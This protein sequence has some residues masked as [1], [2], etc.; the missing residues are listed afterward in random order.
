MIRT[1]ILTIGDESAGSEAAVAMRELLGR[2]PF[3]E[4]DYS[5]VPDE[6]A[7]IRAQLRIWADGG[8]VDLVLTSG[9]IGLS[10]RSRAPEATREVLERELPGLPELMR[11]VACGR[12]PRAA[13]T[14]AVAGVRRRTVIV[15]LPAG[16]PDVREALG[17]IVALLPSAVAA[18]SD[19]RATHA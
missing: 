5:F 13:L 18:L 2:G 17:A 1:A 10:L 4:V 14:R 7:R 8:D 16:G 9:G 6:Q 12:D 3:T 11:R 15:N 19:P